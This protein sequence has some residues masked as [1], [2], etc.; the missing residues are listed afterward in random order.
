MSR[1]AAAATTNLHLHLEKDAAL[2]IDIRLILN[3]RLEGDW[4]VTPPN[5]LEDLP[6]EGITVIIQ[7]PHA[8]GVLGLD[9]RFGIA[10]R[11]QPT[12]GKTERI[13]DR[14]VVPLVV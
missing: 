8:A 4:N 1:A 14:R 6:P 11:P 5:A 12:L 10:L 13:L 3:E 2:Q 9:R 7:H